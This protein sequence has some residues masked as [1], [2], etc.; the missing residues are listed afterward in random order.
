MTMVQTAEEA[1]VFPDVKVASIQM[2]PRIGD[3]V[4]NLRRSADLIEEAA[5]S[6]APEARKVGDYYAS[7]MD[8][9][10]IEARGLRPLQPTLD[11]I[12]AIT[13]RKGLA[14]YLGGTLRA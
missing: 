6:T 8:E 7:Y 3:K 10:G 11:R 12:A 9:A 14:L 2:A 4:A 5:Q 1:N 13:D